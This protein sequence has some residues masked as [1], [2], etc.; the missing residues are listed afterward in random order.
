MKRNIIQRIYTSIK[1]KKWGRTAPGCRKK[2]GIINSNRG[3]SE[4]AINPD[5]AQFMTL[6]NRPIALGLL[7]TVLLEYRLIDRFH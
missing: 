7:V 5:L 2:N 6:M 1:Y 4:Q 3:I